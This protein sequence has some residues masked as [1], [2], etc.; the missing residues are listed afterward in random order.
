M[1]VT[2]IG[3][4]APPRSTD[5][6]MYPSTGLTGKS[7]ECPLSA[8]RSAPGR[9]MNSQTISVSIN[10]GPSRPGWNELGS[11]QSAAEN[12]STGTQIDQVPASGEL[13]SGDLWLIRPAPS[14]NSSSD[15]TSI[16]SMLGPGSLSC[17]ACRQRWVAQQNG[18]QRPTRVHGRSTPGT[19]YPL[20][21]PL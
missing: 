10:V 2:S 7:N 5:A 12:G 8:V 15:N 1:R 11:N 17:P 6:S 9:S 21:A 19:E 16:A 3:L 4:C 13:P 20:L 14:R 18:E